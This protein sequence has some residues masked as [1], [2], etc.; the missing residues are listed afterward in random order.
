LA[1]WLSRR[2]EYAADRFAAAHA[3]AAALADALVR[4]YRDNAATLTPDRLFVAFH[5]AHP[6]ALARIGR[7]APGRFR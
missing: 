6:P 1:A 5:A 7:L 3:D 4:L 2:Q